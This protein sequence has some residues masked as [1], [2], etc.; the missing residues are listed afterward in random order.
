[1]VSNIDWLEPW[2][3]LHTEASSL[4]NELYK[5]VGTSH[6]LNGKRATAIGRCYDCDDVLFE[7][8]DA[9]FKYAVVHL[10]YSTKREENPI[11]PCTTIYMDL[12]DW[13]NRGMKPDNEEYLC[14]E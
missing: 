10:T 3:K 12:N 5:E 6:I 2:D 9:E 1:M 13:I 11:F 14:A 4:E 7:V 8:H